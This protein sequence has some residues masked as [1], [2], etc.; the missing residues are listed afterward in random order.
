MSP[1]EEHVIYKCCLNSTGHPRVRYLNNNHFYDHMIASKLRLEKQIE[2]LAELVG[3]LLGDGSL[4]L[5]EDRH[6]LNNRLKIPFNA[7]E[8]LEYIAY[9]KQMISK[10]FGV[11]PIL[12]YRKK[13]N[14]ADPY[15]FKKEIIVFLTTDVGLMLSPKWG[16]AVIPDMFLEN[17]LD[18]C[19]LRGYFD[20][21]GCVVISDNNGTRYPRLEMK[22]C[23][24]PM[25]TQFIAILKKHGFHFGVYGCGNGEVRV[26]LNGR[27]QLGKWAKEVGF[28][29]PRNSIKAKMMACEIP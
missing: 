19:V 18:L 12:K 11:Y 29:N 22:I 17:N 20:T 16:R 1:K 26:Q 2:K 24:S 15:L 13:E 10:V 7:I 9:V 3:I 5:H 25:Q 23:P 6:T 14:T 8:D 27:K 21:D 4:S 28:S